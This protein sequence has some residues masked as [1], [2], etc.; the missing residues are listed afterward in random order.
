[1][2]SQFVGSSPTLGS[3]LIV[4]SLLEILSPPSLCPSPAHAFSLS[5]KQINFKTKENERKD[6]GD[7][8]E[9]KDN[10]V[11]EKQKEK[12]IKEKGNQRARGKYQDREE[13]GE[14]D[15]NIF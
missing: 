7:W 11:S 10:G 14:M 5:L 13:R 1:M 2:I 3:A 6:R 12:R 9:G 4:Q 15:P 8:H